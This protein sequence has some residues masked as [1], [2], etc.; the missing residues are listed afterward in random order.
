MEALEALPLLDERTA[1]G[2]CTGKRYIQGTISEYQGAL[3][4]MNCNGAIVEGIII[5]R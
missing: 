3:G 2:L 4:P 1:F 5:A